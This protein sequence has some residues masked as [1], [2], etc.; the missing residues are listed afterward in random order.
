MRNSSGSTHFS[1]FRTS[2]RTRHAVIRRDP[3]TCRMNAEVRNYDAVKLQPAKIYVSCIG[4][5]LQKRTNLAPNRDVLH[6][7]ELIYFA[8][9]KLFA[10][11][12]CCNLI[13][14]LQ[15]SPIARIGLALLLRCCEVLISLQIDPIGRILLILKRTC[16]T[17]QRFKARF[18]RR[19][20]FFAR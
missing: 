9:L 12:A 19:R 20:A 11:L 8:G 18:P 4:T 2:S 16:P 1:K 15:T 3:P 14:V 7:C 5:D 17:G 13:S 10:Q 6:F